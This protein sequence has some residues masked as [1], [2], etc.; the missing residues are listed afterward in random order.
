MDRETR[1]VQ[2]DHCPDGVR[3]G[4]VHLQGAAG[5]VADHGHLVPVL[6]HAGHGILLATALHAAVTG[7]SKWSGSGVVSAGL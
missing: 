5:V 4:A 3:V 6:R 2:A 7:I 1:D